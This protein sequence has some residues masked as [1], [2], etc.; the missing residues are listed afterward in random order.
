M[1]EA[2]VELLTHPDLADAVARRARLRV[3][4][5]FRLDGTIERYAARYRALCDG[6]VA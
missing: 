6:A 5:E 4:R 3:E 1:A 2:M